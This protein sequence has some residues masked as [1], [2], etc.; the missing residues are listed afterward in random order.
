MIKVTIIGS[1]NVAEAM[2]VA[3]AECGAG[4]VQLV[5]VASRNV[6]RLN[7]I[8]AVAHCTTTSIDALSPADIYILAVSDDAIEA[9]A[10]TLVRPAGSITLHTAG[11][12]PMGALDGVIYPMQTFTAGRRVDFRAVPL[13]VEGESESIRV[14]ANAL[15]DSVVE[16]SSERRRAL[17]LAAVFACNF[18]NAMLT[19]TNEILSESEIPYALYRPLVEEC[20]AK[21]FDPSTT[22]QAAQ[23]GAAR[24]GDLTIQR[25]HIEQLQGR[26]DLIEI[27][28]TISKYIWETSRK[29]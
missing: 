2:A 25:R 29:I 6:Q 15:S 20:V 28:K 17:H 4:D 14:V 21:A 19:A 11:S 12:V 27:Y 8:S 18:T 13:F 23:T 5:E 7:D 1:G 16:M 26:E 3:L 9:L 24:R 22:P 10:T